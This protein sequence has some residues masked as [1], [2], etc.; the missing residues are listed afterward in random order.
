MVSHFIC[1][2]FNFVFNLRYKKIIGYVPQDDIILSDLTVRENILHSA[3][4]R[5]P[6]TWT[7]QAIQ[8]HVDALL[9]CL[10]LA[11]V[12]HSLVGDATK[13]IISGGQRKRVSIGVELAAAPMAL[14][15][16]E[17]TSGLDATSALS[18]MKLLKSLSRLGVTVVSIIH[19]PRTEIFYC[20]DDILL[21]GEGRQLYQGKASRALGYFQDLGFEFHQDVNPADTIMD[22]IS[23][24]GHKHS[25]SPRSTKVSQL[26]DEWRY[27]Q[28]YDQSIRTPANEEQEEAL[29]RSVALRG[30]S[31]PKQVWFCFFRSITQQIRQAMS[32]YLEISV[33]GIAGL[34]IGLAVFS[35]RGILF[36]GLYQAPYQVL[37]SAANY[38]LVPQLGMLCGLAIGLAGSA[39]GVKIFGEEK[40][41][42]WREASAGHSRSAYY[43]GKVLSTFFRITLS[44]L[45]FTVFFTLMATPLMSFGRLYVANVLY[46]YCIYGLASCVSV[47]TRREDGPLLS[48]VLSLIIG[49]LCGYGPPLATIQQWHLEWFWRACPGTW[50][51]E[52]YFTDNLTPLSHLYNIEAAAQST[53]YTLRHFPLDVG[54]LVII[55]TV[56]RVLAFLGLVLLNRDK[57]L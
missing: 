47:V 52:A 44:A 10:N 17:P 14:F 45:H 55:G 24:Q 15:L 12:Q 13:P 30:A 18:V 33:G 50:F 39:P 2:A 26:I 6:S 28:K 22:I 1:L 19:Q 49:S 23:G 11:H 42:Y 38:T 20:L 29:R 36:T 41:L 46:F 25:R 40:L 32:F 57:Q 54:M 27:R 8:A 34:L 53:G 43:V 48:T 5:L 35:L 31:W 51:T 3:R 7:D 4:V 56:Y 21:L 9:E 16:D 37:S